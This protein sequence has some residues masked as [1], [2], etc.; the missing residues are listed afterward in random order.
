MK[1]IK[2]LSSHHSA[3]ANGLME[4]VFSNNKP[5]SKEIQLK[6]IAVIKSTLSIL[7]PAKKSWIRIK[8]YPKKENL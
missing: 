8:P 1:I 7:R 6:L 3:L 4:F 2:R 5:D